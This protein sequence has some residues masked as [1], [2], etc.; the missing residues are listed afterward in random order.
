MYR[1]LNRTCQLAPDGE[2]LNLA[3]QLAV[4]R[5][6]ELTRK[7]LETVLN[8]QAEEV[9]KKA[10]RA[11]PVLAKERGSIAA[12]RRRRSSRRRAT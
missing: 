12:A 2:V 10:R 8:A 6:R 11:G 1:E 3:E 5:G 4:Q 9:E 7:T